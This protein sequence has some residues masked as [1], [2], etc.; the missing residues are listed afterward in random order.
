MNL[1]IDSKGLDKIEEWR[2]KKFEPKQ[3]GGDN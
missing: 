2:L 1:K 3:S